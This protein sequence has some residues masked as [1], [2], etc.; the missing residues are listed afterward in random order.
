[1]RQIWRQENNK[2]PDQ[3]CQD[4]YRRQP[5]PHALLTR[6]KVQPQRSHSLL[7]S[8]MSHW[9]SGTNV[10]TA[11]SARVLYMICVESHNGAAHRG[12]DYNHA[13][14]I[15]M[16]GLSLSCLEHV[17]PVPVQVDLAERGTKQPLLHSCWASHIF[18]GSP[19]LLLKIQVCSFHCLL[20]SRSN[21][22]RQRACCCLHT[23]LSESWFTFFSRYFDR[24]YILISHDQDAKMMPVDIS[25][26]G[27]ESAFKPS[28][29]VSHRPWVASVFG[30]GGNGRRFRTIDLMTQ[31]RIE[32]K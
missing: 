21:L 20:T 14:C 32:D 10:L 11:P 12:N 26:C 25:L 24:N 18:R 29:F 1:M 7:V 30:D 19:T 8:G 4:S 9:T 27:P 6:L 13:G 28:H 16:V 3:I 2:Q 31:K 5:R 17:S 23:L 15:R 22:A